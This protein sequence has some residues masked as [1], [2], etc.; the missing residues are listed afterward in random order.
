MAK[1]SNKNLIRITKRIIEDNQICWHQKLKI[2]LWT[3]RITPKRAIGNYFFMLVYGREAR[4]PI[5]LEFIA[6]E[7]AHQLK[8]DGNDAMTVRIVE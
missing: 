6:L 2:A 7:L 1:S 8:L 3:D 5:S 4:L